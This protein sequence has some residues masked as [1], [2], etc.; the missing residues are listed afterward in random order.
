M[1]LT[2]DIRYKGAARQPLTVRGTVHYQ[3][4]DDRLCFPP[5]AVPV[6]WTLELAPLEP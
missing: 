1:A 5:D 6:S 3:A 2:R 4:C